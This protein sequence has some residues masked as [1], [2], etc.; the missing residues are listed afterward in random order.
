MKRFP[1]LE[2]DLHSY[3]WTDPQTHFR[4]RDESPRMAD[5]ERL[6]RN[7]AANLRM[8]LAIAGFCLLVIGMIWGVVITEAHFD[9]QQIVG[10]AV[11]RNSDLAIAFEQYAGRT[12]ESADSDTR[13]LQLAFARGDSRADLQKLLIERAADRTLFSLTSITDAFGN[14][15]M[16]SYGTLP[17]PIANLS[18][19]EYFKIHKNNDTGKVFVGKPI[20]SRTTG[21][22]VV[23]ITRRLNRPDGSF[24][25]IVTVQIEPYRFTEF[26][27]DVTLN[28]GDILVLVGLDGI[29]RSRR[30]GQIQSSGEDI[31]KGS[32]LARQA[33]QPSGD[34]YGRGNINAEL[35]YFS[36]RTLPDYPL[37]VLVS[38]PE[39]EVLKSFYQSR[40]L[41]YVGASI[42]TGLAVSFAALLIANLSQRK[43]AEEDLS[44]AKEIAESAN[45][46]KSEFLANMS[47]EIRT[48]M[49]GVI[50]MTGLALETELSIEQREYLSMAQNSASSL[51]ALLN[52]ILDF[53]KIE[54]GKLDFESIGFQLSSTL[55]ST[56]KT[57]GMRAAEKGLELSCHVLPDVPE[58]I[59][60]DPTRLRQ[61]LVNLVGNAMKFT[62]HGEIVVRVEN[63]SLRANEVVIHF[64]VRDTGIGIN[65]ENQAAIFGAFTQADNSITRKHGGTGLGLAICKRLVEMMDGRIWVES[66]FGHGSS[67][68]FTSRFGIQ[69]PASS[70]PHD[71][72]MSALLGLNVWVVDDNSTNRHVLKE[73]L[74]SWGMIPRLFDNGQSV[75]DTLAEPGLAGQH[76]PMIILDVQMPNMDGFTVIEKMAQLPNG[77]L[78]KLIVMT[79]AGVRGDAARCRELG[80]A[81]Y[82]TKPVSKA[83]LLQAIKKTLGHIERQQIASV[84]LITHHSLY[85]DRPRLSILLAEDNRVNQLMAV[86]L[87]EK[88]GHTVV[89]AG[90][91][92][93]ALLAAGRQHFDVILMDMQ[94]PEMD[95]LQATVLIRESETL[96]GKHIPIFAMTANA[97][98]GDKEKCLSAGMDGYLSKPINKD[99]LFEMLRAIQPGTTVSQSV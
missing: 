83:D 26:Y 37:V 98:A 71:V 88:R 49:N 97:M 89:I 42:V 6:R 90:T 81:A 17:T 79:S 93:E 31:S 96:S 58:A 72:S 95:G 22:T 86:R 55:D 84:P 85:E 80:V 7:Y 27:K 4:S 41:Y 94:M 12:I 56:M 54:A 28:S 18:D 23:P 64:S 29:V 78:P 70:Q 13:Y 63:E 82:L 59:V 24:G 46:A 10:A 60:G 76:S 45:R 87:L 15:L 43:R 39:A 25:G 69:A 68:H 66:E 57:L 50:G 16:S 5:F 9:R 51:L 53:S 73:I 30:F 38:V 33:R 19:R 32:V 77:T 61:V 48:P 8:D 11:K 75:L 1:L 91:G 20:V 65:P 14:L 21:K 52:D 62:S 35:R 99:E 44:K 2:V 74:S 92:H 3:D 34:Y 36:Y 67:F 40:T 47:H